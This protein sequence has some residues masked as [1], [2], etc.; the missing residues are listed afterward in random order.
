MCLPCPRLIRVLRTTLHYRYVHV[1]RQW[2][3]KRRFEF[4]FLPGHRCT[5]I[6]P[7]F[8]CTSKVCRVLSNE[9]ILLVDG[10]QKGFRSSFPFFSF[11]DGRYSR[12]N[13]KKKR[14]NRRGDNVEEER[15]ERSAHFESVEDGSPSLR[16]RSSRWKDAYVASC[17]AC[18]V[19]RPT[20]YDH[21]MLS[22]TW[23]V[24]VGTKYK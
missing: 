12:F 8:L 16:W 21:R 18:V 22:V 14:V 10:K 7:S 4:F 13:F 9:P 3:S 1:L 24:A 2:R 6:Q 15:N 20:S 23:N 17:R 11:P 5:G 19:S